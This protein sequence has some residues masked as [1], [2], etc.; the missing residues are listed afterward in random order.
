MVPHSSCFVCATPRS[1]TQLLTGLLKSTGIA[2]RPEEYFW[3][4]GR[5][6]PETDA[7]LAAILE[8]GMTPNGVFGAKVMWRSFVDLLRVLASLGLSLEG[9]YPN[10]RFVWLRREGVVAEAVS[11]LKAIQTQEWFAGDRRKPSREARFDAGAI[12]QLVREVIEDNRGWESWFPENDVDPFVVRYEDLFADHIGVTQ[13]VL[14]FLGLPR[15]VSVQAQTQRQT[16]A[17]NAEW[18][19]RYRRLR[20]TAPQRRGFLLIGR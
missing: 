16:D 1:G 9:L 18:I 10:L 7:E 8:Q 14:A 2:G 5:G 4:D 3:R 11:H 15:G 13:R 19:A 6:V 12:D 20:R 17:L